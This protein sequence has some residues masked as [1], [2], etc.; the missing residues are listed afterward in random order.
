[1]RSD[2]VL[3]SL[4][5]GAY[6]N[7]LDDEVDVGQILHLGA[8]GQSFPGRISV[9]LGQPALANILCEKLVGELQALVNRSLRRIDQP[10]GDRSPLCC[11]ESNSKTLLE[12]MAVCR[13]C[14]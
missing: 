2:Y 13:P 12:S 4:L 9:G 3:C 5:Q 14:A 10:D 11:Y 7:S 1:M 6:R 8:R